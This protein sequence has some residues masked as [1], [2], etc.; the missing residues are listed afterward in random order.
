MLKTLPPTLRDKKR[1][2]VFEIIYEDELSESEIINIIRNATINYYGVWGTSKSN[3]WLVY[4]DFPY[5]ILRCRHTEVDYVRSALIFVKEYK[6]KPI[7]IVVLGVSGTVRKA[8]IKF[9]GITPKR[10]Y[11]KRLKESKSKNN[12]KNN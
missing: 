2:L 1:Y 7:N 11:M 3:P 6:N 8:K 10:L 5:G 4:Y 12:S 9:L